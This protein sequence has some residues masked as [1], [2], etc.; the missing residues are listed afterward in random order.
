M[1]VEEEDLKSTASSNS[2]FFAYFQLGKFFGEISGASFI[3]KELI[4]NVET[5]QSQTS[6]PSKFVFRRFV[7]YLF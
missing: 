1:K 3:L 6:S 4:S 7:W 2:C 5:D